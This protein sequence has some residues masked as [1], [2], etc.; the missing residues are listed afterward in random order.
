MNNGEN[1]EKPPPLW[2]TGNNIDEEPVG[3]LYSDSEYDGGDGN[4]VIHNH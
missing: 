2:Q 1:G 3:N 4:N